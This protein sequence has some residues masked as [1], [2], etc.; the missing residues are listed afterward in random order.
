MRLSHAPSLDPLACTAPVPYCVGSAS[1]VKCS[2][3]LSLVLWAG[4]A[5][6]TRA[7]QVQLRHSIKHPSQVALVMFLDCLQLLH[8][9]D[10][11]LVGGHMRSCP[12]KRCPHQLHVQLLPCVSQALLLAEAV[13]GWQVWRPRPGE[14]PLSWWSMPQWITPSAWLWAS[15]GRG[16]AACGASPATAPRSPG[17]RQCF[18]VFCFGERCRPPQMH[19]YQSRWH[20]VHVAVAQLR[21]HLQVGHHR[22]GA[23]SGGR[24][25]S[26]PL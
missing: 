17:R 22:C 12:S 7:W 6:L 1:V 24:A 16:S 20:L 14:P 2:T 21:V 18:K 15:P 4:T 10:G 13:L 8:H 19:W 3:F 26:S 11:A 5:S 25:P 23:L 9:L